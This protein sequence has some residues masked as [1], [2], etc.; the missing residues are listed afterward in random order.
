M[1][2]QLKVDLLIPNLIQFSYSIV[3][4]EKEIN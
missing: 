4:T 2:K 1:N 3:T